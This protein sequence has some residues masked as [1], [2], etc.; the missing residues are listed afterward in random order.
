MRRRSVIS[1]VG[2]PW[3]TTGSKV[4]LAETSGLAVGDVEGEGEGLDDGSGLDE[5][6][7]SATE[8]TKAPATAPT[9][10]VRFIMPSGVSAN[11]MRRPTRVGARVFPESA[12]SV[13]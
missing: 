5:Q 3:S 1:A 12:S 13:E 10:T 7:E 11:G 8:S 2:A 4:G 9:E 6:A